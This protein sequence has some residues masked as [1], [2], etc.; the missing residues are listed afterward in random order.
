MKEIVY[1]SYENMKQERALVAVTED[2]RESDKTGK[3]VEV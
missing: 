2:A 3:V 1:N